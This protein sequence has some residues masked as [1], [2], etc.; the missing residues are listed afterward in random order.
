M[1][2][3]G[4]VTDPVPAVQQMSRWRWLGTVMILMAP[5]MLA[6]S[7]VMQ[8]S[9]T[10]DEYQALPHGL[11]VI[12][13]GDFHL[14]TTTQPL[15]QYLPALPLRFVGARL[16]TSRL[17]ESPSTWALGLQ[18]MQEN[19]DDYQRYFMVGRM[20][21]VLVLGATCL[22]A[23]GFSRSLYGATIGQQAGCT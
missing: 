23:Y 22:L 10:V 15:S 14:A 5:M 3:P 4:V 9:V 21:S 12:Q 16:D 2:N 6:A 18:F 19:R 13:T 17:S 11:A 7:A 8:K 1:T 20:V